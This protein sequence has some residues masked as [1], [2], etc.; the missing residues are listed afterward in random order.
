MMARLIIKRSK[1][2]FTRICHTEFVT[3][4]SRNTQK[5]F[6]LYGCFF[7]R[8][9]E[10]AEKA[11]IISCIR[12]IREIRVP[13]QHSLYGCLFNRPAEIAEKAEIF[14]LYGCIRAIREIRVP[15]H[16]SLYGSFLKVPQKSRN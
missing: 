10:I 3:Q 15:L 12:V 4:K 7:N 14:S 13:L 8:P 11:E 6:S 9:A 1:G 2:C 5:Y 16:H